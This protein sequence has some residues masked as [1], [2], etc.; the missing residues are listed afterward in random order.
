MLYDPVIPSTSEGKVRLAQIPDKHWTRGH[1]IL[2][3]AIAPVT[4]VEY[5]LE[6]GGTKGNKTSC[7]KNGEFL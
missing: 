1:D 2:G 3:P 6:N 4:T 5:L 7:W